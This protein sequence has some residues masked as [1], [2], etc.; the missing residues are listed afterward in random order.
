[1]TLDENATISDIERFFLILILF[2]M[3]TA[4]KNFVVQGRRDLDR[5]AAQLKSAK[6]AAPV[7][8]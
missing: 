6:A 5:I 2:K 1:M 4:E 7:I 3:K 8:A